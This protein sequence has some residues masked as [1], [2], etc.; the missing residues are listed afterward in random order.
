ML[1]DG[2]IANIL[3]IISLFAVLCS[4]MV[5]ISKNPIV[6]WEKLS[7]SGD[8]L[9]LLIPSSIWKYICGWINLS[10]KVVI[11]KIGENLMGNRGSKSTIGKSVVKEQRVY[12]SYFGNMNP[13]LRCILTGLERD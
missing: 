7:N 2:Y 3:N 11:H 9:K 12:G 1:T 8:T 5:I 4:V 13:R 6:L 10:G